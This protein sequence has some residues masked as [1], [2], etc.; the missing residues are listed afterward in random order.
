M[1]PETPLAATSPLVLIVDH[2]ADAR[3]MYAEYLQFRGYRVA[4]AA[5]GPEAIW[6]ARAAEPAI[7]VMDTHLPAISGADTLRL[8]R[9]NPALCNIPILALTA[10][11]MAHERAAAQMAGFDAV[12]TKPCLP[13][14]LVE[15]IEHYLE[16]QRP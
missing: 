16:R 12:I 5:S 10:S 15:L 6:L 9:D 13:Q 11:A 4:T 1:P 7:V 8:F 2:F 3:E 14:D